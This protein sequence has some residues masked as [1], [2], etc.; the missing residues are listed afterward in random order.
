MSFRRLLQ[1]WRTRFCLSQVGQRLPS[2]RRQLRFFGSKAIG[3]A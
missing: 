1:N 2:S 3:R